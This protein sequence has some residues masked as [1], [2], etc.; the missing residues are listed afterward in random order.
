MSLSANRRGHLSARQCAPLGALA[1]L[2]LMLPTPRRREPLAAEP[3]AFRL[4]YYHNMEAHERSGSRRCGEGLGERG[5]C[6]PCGS[7]PPRAGRAATRVVRQRSPPARQGE[8]PTRRQELAA[9]R[10]R[11]GARGVWQLGA[12]GCCKRRGTRSCARVQPRAW[13][14]TLPRG[15]GGVAVPVLWSF[16]FAAFAARDRTALWTGRYPDTGQQRVAHVQCSG[17]WSGQQ[18][19]QEEVWIERSQLGHVL[20]SPTLTLSVERG[21]NHS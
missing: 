16:T 12:A 9:G 11:G 17:Q 13:Q 8:P 3:L 21:S 5:S 14:R 2:C 7:K 1:L 6:L 20:R 19:Q 10:A 4:T 15:S 18:G